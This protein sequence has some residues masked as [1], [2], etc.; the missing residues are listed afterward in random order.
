MIKLIKDSIRL[1]KN[2]KNYKIKPKIKF[3]IDDDYIFSFIPTI[4]WQ[5]WIYRYLDSGVIDIW[6]LH[7]HIIIGVWKKINI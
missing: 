3:C 2:Y 1:K 4:T 6:W 5:P 7:F